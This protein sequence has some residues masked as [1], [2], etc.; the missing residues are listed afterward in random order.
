MSDPICRV[1]RPS[2]HTESFHCETPTWESTL[3][4]SLRNIQTAADH[5][6]SHCIKSTADSG[7]RLCSLAR[8]LLILIDCTSKRSIVTLNEN[9][10]FQFFPFYTCTPDPEGHLR[11]IMTDV[12][13]G[14]PTQTTS[15]GHNLHN[16]L[17]LF[18]SLTGAFEQCS[19]RIR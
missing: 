9:R 1:H 10:W 19:F 16:N 4:V 18:S 17:K 11:V 12:P 3:N 13:N 8:P 15:A 6:D 7:S 14:T 2:P 5:E